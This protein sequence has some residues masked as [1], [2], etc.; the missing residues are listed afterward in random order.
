VHYDRFL[1]RLASDRRIVVAPL[2]ELATTETDD[3]AV[4]GLRHDVDSRLDAALELA[5]HEHARGLRATYF[6]LHTASYWTRDRVL[7]TSLRHLQDDLEHEVGLHNDLVSL[8]RLRGL[9]P[10]ATLHDELDWLRRNGIAVRGSAAHGS[11]D[12]RL[13]GYH[14]YFLFRECREP[15]PDRPNVAAVANP[16]PM[17][18]AGLEYEAYHL[19]Y[20][21]YFSDGHFDRAGRRWHTD[22]LE[23]SDLAPGTRAVV[24]IHPCHWDRSAAVKGLRMYGRLARRL[25]G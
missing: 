1:A 3:R 6:V 10:V 24:L 4:V 14:N 15:T 16:V 2:G 5:R 17:T 25:L 13:G 20:D 19:P 7:A 21:R 12:A 18:A 8:S 11:L 22:E 9:D 23:L